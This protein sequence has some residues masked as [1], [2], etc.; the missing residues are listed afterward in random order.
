MKYITSPFLLKLLT[1]SLCFSSKCAPSTERKSRERLVHQFAKLKKCYMI[2]KALGKI[3][4][5]V[6]ASSCLACLSEIQKI[7]SYFKAVTNLAKIR[8]EIKEAMIHKYTKTSL[9]YWT[10]N[11]NHR[12]RKTYCRRISDMS[13]TPEEDFIKQFEHRNQKKLV[14]RCNYRPIC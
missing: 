9:W 10:F 6:I 8:R 5:I 14:K 1:Q 11:W 7:R 3:D 12:I 2:C 4:L 13:S